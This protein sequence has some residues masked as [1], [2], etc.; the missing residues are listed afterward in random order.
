MQENKKRGGAR[1]GTGPKLKFGE[2]TKTISVR[3]PESKYEEIKE[4]IKLII[5]QLK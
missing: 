3:V 2:R 1:K 5:S 4:Q